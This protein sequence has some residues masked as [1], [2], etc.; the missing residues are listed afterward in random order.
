MS[1]QHVNVGSENVLVLCA[2]P[3][4]CSERREKA[5]KPLLGFP[6]KCRGGSDDI[7]VGAI[8]PLDIKF[9]IF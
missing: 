2:S 3:S 9:K 1:A 5:S 8:L 7:I 6:W 4:V